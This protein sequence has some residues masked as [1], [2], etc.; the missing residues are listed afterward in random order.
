MNKKVKE[1][2]RPVDAEFGIDSRYK[3]K[4][5]REQDAVALMQARLNRMKDLSEAQILQAR[6]MQLKLRMENYL[7]EPVYD[8]QNH[9]CQFLESY[10]DA[11]YSR[12]GDFAKDINVTANF[13]SK[14]IHNHRE[15]NEAFMLKLMIHSEKVFSQVGPFKKTTWYQ[16]YYHEKLCETMA[17][18]KKW[19]PALEKQVKYRASI[20]S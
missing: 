12:R 14:I 13:L 15:P 16:I 9:F 19:R 8:K 11:I 6:L 7:N 2:N 18:Q 4:I 5:Q 17:N 20:L 3:T 10:V 1:N